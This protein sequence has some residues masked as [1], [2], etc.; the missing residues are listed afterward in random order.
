MT[1]NFYALIMA[2]G[3]GTRLWPLSRQGHPKQMLPLIDERS[4]F[5]IAVQ[6]LTG[7]FPTERIF[8]VTNRKQSAELSNQCPEIPKENYLLEPEPRGTAAA[9]GLAAAY[10]HHRDPEA[11][12]A[13]LTADHYIGNEER[14][15]EYLREAKEIASQGHLVT[16]GI[17]PT[18]PAT[19]YGYIQQGKE[20]VLNG[21]PSAFEVDRFKEKP[22]ESEAKQLLA[23]GDHSWNSGM[24]IWPT[25]LILKEF[26]RQMP[27]LHSSLQTIVKHWGSP[28]R[29]EILN[30]EWPNV[31]SQTIDYGIME[32]AENVAVI[33]AK[34]MAWN[35]VGS[36]NSLFEVLEPDEDGNVILSQ[37]HMNIK[38]RD[39]L[40]H[41]NG[42][43]KMLVTIGVENLVIVDTGDVL[44]VCSKEH[45]QDVR[46]VVEHLKE[47]EIKGYL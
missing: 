2:G 5:Q 13:V 3:G 20:L 17:E 22:D 16:L 6:R 23:S 9:I 1:E 46:K 32:H 10:L 11:V 30:R 19:Q 24:F 18:Y 33:P 25:A 26:E 35:D 15:L 7:L 29:D 43:S 44:L 31:E 8:V 36:W 12:L 38:S 42:Q 41:S 34:D 40:V 4:L 45:A 37:N 28:Q 21:K 47:N 14:F 39:S 27:S